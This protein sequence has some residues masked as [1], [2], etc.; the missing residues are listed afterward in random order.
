MVTSLGKDR[1]IVG[2]YLSGLSLSLFIYVC[3]IICLYIM[4]CTCLSGF[5]RFSGCSVISQKS[6]TQTWANL[7]L[8]RRYIN[9]NFEGVIPK[10]ETWDPPL[11]G[12]PF[13]CSIFYRVSGKTLLFLTW[14]PK[15]LRTLN[16]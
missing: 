9:V 8:D 4:C 1:P 13:D 7:I 15:K 11:N 12:G 10:K 2:P 16:P 3:A 14:E 5:S 6:S